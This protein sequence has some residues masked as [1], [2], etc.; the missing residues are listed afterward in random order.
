V[1][2]VPAVSSAWL[3]IWI[4]GAPRSP[5]RRGRT[6]R[7][8]MSRSTAERTRAQL[9]AICERNK[10]RWP[11]VDGPARVQFIVYR[12]RLLDPMVNLPASLKTYQ[13]GICRELLPGGDGP[14]SPYE[15]LPPQ[16]VQ[17]ARTEPERVLVRIEV[18]RPP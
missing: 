5:N 16:Q 1:I 10:H 7:G 9:A 18:A 13:D 15:W 8:R 14:R 3:E 4:D 2:T 17:V 12:C 6:T 11:R